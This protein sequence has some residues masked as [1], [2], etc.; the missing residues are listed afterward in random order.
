LGFAVVLAVGGC[1]GI[2]NA[3]IEQAPVPET[4][5]AGATVVDGG[6]FTVAE[7]MNDTWN[8]VG[9]VLVRL[10]GVTYE[11][12]AQMLGIHAVRY[13]GERMLIRTQAV[14][15]RDPTDRMRTRVLALKMDGKPNA[16]PAAIE[17]LDLLRQRV[18]FEIGK[19]RQPIQLKKGR[20][21]G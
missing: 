20:R 2:H 8:T 3:R 6:E 14:V 21:P 4:P 19:Y 16:S 1:S 17:L 11:S 9:Q 18:P 5:A 12:R 13:R 10:D 7:S 15:M